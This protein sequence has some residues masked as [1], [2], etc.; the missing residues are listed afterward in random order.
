MIEINKIYAESN[1]ETVKRMPDGFVD[2]IVTSPPYD[3]LR[4]YNGYSFQFE[5][6]APEL[7][8]ILK[9][10]GVLVWVVADG[11]VDG[12]ES[13]TSF[14]QALFFKDCGF[15]LHDTMIYAKENFIP[16]S[17]NRYEQAFEYMFVLSK[18]KPK[19]FNGLREV[20]LTGGASYNYSKKGSNVE[21][22]GFR[23]RD[24][25]V[26]TAVTK[27]KTNIFYYPTGATQTKHP[28]PF[29]EQLAADQIASWSNEG[30]LV[31]DPFLGS[32]TTAKMAHTLNR[33]WIGSELSDKYVEM[34]NKRL[35]P[36]LRQTNLF[37]AS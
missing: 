32:G 9:Q 11:T 19:T 35:D 1:L 24:E 26:T 10:G 18:G 29:P 28:A 12:S 4:K 2:L 30:D 31:Y 20:S 21:E 5:E 23:R 15:K 34:A 7:F 3:G 25:V 37:K 8:R 13:G 22:G 33:N 36:F 14:R 16:L 17:H 6:L 27:L